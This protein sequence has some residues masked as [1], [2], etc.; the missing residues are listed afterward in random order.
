MVTLSVREER[1]AWTELG[2][3]EGRERG[4]E[5]KEGGEPDLPDE[6]SIVY[7]VPAQ[8]RSDPAVP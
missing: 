8:V 1:L 6:Q 7:C 4:R 5:G 3:T 2:E